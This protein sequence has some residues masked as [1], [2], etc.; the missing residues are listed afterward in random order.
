MKSLIL[1]G[2][3]SSGKTTL[4]S[5]L[6]EALEINWLSEFSRSFLN[7]K[8]GQYD[9]EDLAIMAKEAQTILNK[10]TDN[11]LILDTD[12]LTYKIW[13]SI[14][15]NKTD[16]WIDDHLINNNEKLYLLCYPDLEWSPDPLR[17]NPHDRAEIFSAYEDLLLK[18]NLNYFIICG[19]NSRLSSALEIATDYFNF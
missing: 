2:P 4:A 6:S 9:Y 12:I 17:E 7:K 1:T 15:Y 8:N 13:S 3:E 19:K 16:S 11:K 5:Q 10:R 18:L 14:K